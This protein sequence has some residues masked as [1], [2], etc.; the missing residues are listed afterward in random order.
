M[1]ATKCIFS[2]GNIA[3]DCFNGY[4]PLQEYVESKEKKIIFNHAKFHSRIL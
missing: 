2:V 4:K 3:E 1:S